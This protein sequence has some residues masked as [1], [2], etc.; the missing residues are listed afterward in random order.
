MKINLTR[1]EHKNYLS[2]T[3]QDIDKYDI[4]EVEEIIL[5]DVPNYLPINQAKEYVMKCMSKLRHGGKL[6][7]NSVNVYEL[8]RLTA[9]G[10][11]STDD[12]NKDVFNG[13]QSCFSTDDIIGLSQNMNHQLH[14]LNINGTN[15][16]AEL[17][18][19]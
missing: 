18:R 3:P 6:Y 4:G 1:K 15:I 14:S 13:K 9:M 16:E 19:P 5:G 11:I 7:L 10:V 17:I 8:A 12:F 2:V